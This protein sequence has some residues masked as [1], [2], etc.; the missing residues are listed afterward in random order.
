MTLVCPSCGR[1]NP[2]DARFCAGCATPLAV[3]TMRARE[4]RK[5]VTVV[6]A[7]LVGSTAR[8]ERLDPEDVRAILAPY[9]DRLRREL[10]RF[11]GT[12]E[13]F[14]GDAVVGVFGAPAVH[15][16]DPERAVRAALA[17]Q[18]AI[19]E[20][21]EADPR[22]E[23]EVRVGVHTGGALVSLDARPELGEAMVVGDVMNT[24]ARLQAAAPP[25]GV[26]VGEAT[27]R[28]TARVVEYREA[29]AV[30]GKGKAEPI[31]AWVAIAPLAQFGVDVG[32]AG[33][34]PL[35]GR[36]RE[37]DVLAGALSRARAEREP[38]LVTLVGVPGIGKSR[39]VYE[40][41]QVVDADPE[42]IVWRQGRSLPYGAGVP[43]WALGEMVKAQAGILESDSEEEGSGK[44]RHSARDL[45]EDEG[46]ASWTE[47]HLRVLVGLG[48]EETSFEENRD[49]SLAAWRRFL[50]A[51]AEWRPTVL[52]FEDLH[53]AD[54]NLLEFVNELTD[55]VRDSPLLVV[56]TAR[57]ELLE[58]RPGWG[59][60]K[61]NTVTLSL[62]PLSDDDTAR[63]LA[64]LLERAVL[65]ADTQATLLA[66][67][68]GN[69]LYAEEFARVHALGDRGAAIPDSVQG[70]VAARIDA[71]PADEKAV[72]Q[73]GAVLGKVF[74]TGAV[75]ALAGVES[76]VP[77]GRLRALERKE[78]VRRERRSTV[79]GEQQYVFLHTLIR[80]VAYGQLPR[81]ERVDKHR[82]AAEWI[83]SL[84]R[85]EDHADVI[86]HHY[87][88]ALE[89]ARAAGV[90]STDLEERTRLALRRAGDRAFRLLALPAAIRF[91]AAALELWPLQDSER[92]RIQLAYAK[93]SVFTEG[94]DL[95]DTYL[96]ELRDLLLASAD[97]E[98]AA[99]AEW[100]LSQQAQ[101]RGDRDAANEHLKQA[102]S[103]VDEQPPSRAK[104]ELLMN[105][106][107][108]HMLNEDFEDAVRVG[109]LAARIAE[110]VGADE[111]RAGA[112]LNIGAA[113]VWLG[114]V[115]AGTPDVERGIALAREIRSFQLVRGLGLFRDQIFELGDLARSAGIL[116][117]ALEEA[118]R[119]GM[120]GARRWFRG[121]RAVEQFHVGAWDDALEL[122]GDVLGDPF[123]FDPEALRVRSLIRLARG[124]QG[125]AHED[126][127]RALER[128]RVGLDPQVLYPALVVNALVAD[129]AGARDQAA[130][131]VDEFL[132]LWHARPNQHVRSSWIVELARVLLLLGREDELMVALQSVTRRTLWAD[133]AL[134]MASRSWEHAAELFGRIGSRSCEA[135]ARIGAGEAL[136]AAGRRAEAD[137]HLRAAA[138][139][140]SSVGADAY[141]RETEDLL[142][143]TA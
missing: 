72:L 45:I 24:G 71:L 67:A 128:A 99:D 34:A 78:F 96:G 55:W 86:S 82:L 126:A 35:V 94:L 80:D 56:A 38:Q 132:S 83:E 37:L 135:I 77:E 7:D 102:L 9:H 88:A 85:P 76:V 31:P 51:L 41:S 63:L 109:E 118:E 25:G 98:G 108:R 116:T 65:A 1:E 11:G 79:A 115:D 139:F 134:A 84:G 10:E 18:E 113:R 143:A 39:L 122:L 142:A 8:A 111:A 97:V 40:L 49:E 66:A 5:V 105:L 123:W 93:A 137:V 15:E 26:L 23:L 110:E 4:E 17:I 130:K 136:V 46:E 140:W 125:G 42:L 61:R 141:L 119:F 70:I 14:I 114:D 20:L 106:A 52:V 2:D 27:Y 33:R 16:D 73:A 81:A 131:Y 28:A 12:V 59:G 21:N 54:D 62:S 68:G 6:F 47:R 48:P 43:F 103:L 92:G 95:A 112:L 29:D 104:A 60:G 69:P 117:E 75:S 57:P 89:L 13:K 91:Y 90:A 53:W 30:I 87:G 127:D 22:L 44:L 101:L 120:A 64:A 32:G 58:R 129:A 121:E 36:N 3:E 124:D 138:A 100:L 19:A 133:A 50:E 74:W 107:G